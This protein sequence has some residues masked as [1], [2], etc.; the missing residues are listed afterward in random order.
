MYSDGGVWRVTMK[1]ATG[2]QGLAMTRSMCD[3]VAKSFGVI[4][5]PDVSYVRLCAAHRAIVLGS[6]GVSA[7]PVH[8]WATLRVC[9]TWAAR[10]G[11]RA[12]RLGAVTGRSRHGGGGCCPLLQIWDMIT[13]RE[14]IHM[15]GGCASPLQAAQKLTRI[16]RARWVTRQNTSDDIT[17]VVAFL[18]GEP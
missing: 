13:S 8:P 3:V 5:T 2:I 15:L 7:A 1:L 6:D 10:L 14:A 16:A 17:V 11:A 9:F 18:R 12:C 4:S